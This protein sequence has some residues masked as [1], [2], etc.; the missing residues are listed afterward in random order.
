MQVLTF[1]TV[2][3]TLWVNYIDNSNAAEVRYQFESTGYKGRIHYVFKNDVYFVKVYGVGGYYAY[4]RANTVTITASDIIIELLHRLFG[5]LNTPYTFL[6]FI[7][8]EDKD[9]R[10]C[11]DYYDYVINDQKLRVYVEVGGKCGQY[12]LEPGIVVS[13]AISGKNITFT[14][15]D[16]TVSYDVTGILLDKPQRLADIIYS[17]ILH[18][19]YDMQFR[20]IL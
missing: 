13:F 16:D 18:G 2:N 14:V 15:N 19:N 7:A 5:K 12:T 8:R 11:S 6:G 10:I 20:V 3:G 4:S 17:K 9:F 1:S